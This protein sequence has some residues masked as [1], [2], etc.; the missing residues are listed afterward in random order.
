M[1]FYEVV[2]LTFYDLGMYML[3]F[4]RLLDLDFRNYK[5]S[6]IVIGIGSVMIGGCAALGLSVPVT[7]VMNILI[8]I[9]VLRYYTWHE[10]KK[11]TVFFITYIGMT[12]IIYSV[13]FIVILFVEL[14][15]GNVTFNILYGLLSQT[16][17]IILVYFISK[18]VPLSIFLQVIE[19]RL[20]LVRIILINMGILFLG[21]SFYWNANF[22]ATMDSII[23]IAILSLVSMTINV[24][25]IRGGFVDKQ[26]KEK[27]EI[28]ETYFPI[29][30][31]LVEEVKYIQHDYNNHIQALKGIAAPKSDLE[32]YLSEHQLNT[33]M[34]QLL[35]LD[36]KIIMGLLYSKY[37]QCQSLGIKIVFKIK[38]PWIQSL[39]TDHELVEIFGILIQNAI[40]AVENL[41][42]K[43][44]AVEYSHDED[45]NKLTVINSLDINQKIDIKK[46]FEFQTST[47]SSHHGIGLYKLN[48]ILRK[49]EDR[50]QV[51]HDRSLNQVEITT[52][53]C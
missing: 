4:H 41:E 53:F 45:K 25:L 47:K 35:I 27:L 11:W 48:R 10:I 23:T 13:Q 28:Y 15:I 49:Y 32:K 9:S 34:P 14:T 52:S 24:L 19:S 42:H 21:L 29:I 18:Y 26:H 16:I 7:Q 20:S 40:E 31:Q 33:N 39:Y 5:K 36:N 8:A 46:M 43:Y 3:L 22:E 44:I 2:V 38:H 50:V 12:V 30:E 17:G 6:L 37:K 1:N 51:Y